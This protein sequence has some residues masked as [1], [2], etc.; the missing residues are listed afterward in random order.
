MVIK[1]EENINVLD[2]VNKGACMG[3]DAINFILDKVTDKKFKK[4]LEK[5]AKE[6]KDITKR[7]NQ[8]Y[9]QYNK[10]DTPHETNKMEKTM[11][12][13]GIEMRTMTDDSDAKLAELLFKG[14]NMG[15]LEGRR[16]LNDKSM[17]KEVNTLVEDYVEMQEKNI[18][19]LKK[20]L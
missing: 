11:T 3:V 5:Q 13:F 12:Y 17:D 19:N 1:M 18:E 20:Y 14:T 7:V 2:E 6:Y 10:E 16:L 15:I 4:L 9:S 8:I